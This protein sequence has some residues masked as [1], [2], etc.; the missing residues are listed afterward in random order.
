VQQLVQVFPCIFVGKSNI[1]WDFPL[2]IIFFW[3]FLANQ[4][5]SLGRL[6]YYPWQINF[7]PYFLKK[8]LRLIVITG[9]QINK[10]ARV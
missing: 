5:I 3:Y 7:P 8:F 6:R 9:A 1:S 4:G 2:Q 10:L